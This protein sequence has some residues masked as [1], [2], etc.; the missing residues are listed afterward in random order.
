MENRVLPVLLGC[1]AMVQGPPARAA[2]PVTVEEPAPAPLRLT[3]L[4]QV[5]ERYYPGAPWPDPSR[6]T[7]DQKTLEQADGLTHL[8]GMVAGFKVDVFTTDGRTVTGGTL[9]NA[10]VIPIGDEA[11][12][13]AQIEAMEPLMNRMSALV[14]QP[15]KTNDEPARTTQLA[16]GYKSMFFGSKA[17]Y[18]NAGGYAIECLVDFGSKRYYYTILETERAGSVTWRFRKD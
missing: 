2:V 7:M 12:A 5:I 11:A 3:D 6:I 13:K 14:H 1:L 8:R 4:G 17:F 10:Q 18:L 15:Y 16:S 9:E